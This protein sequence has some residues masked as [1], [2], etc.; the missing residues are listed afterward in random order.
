[1]AFTVRAVIDKRNWRTLPCIIAAMHEQH[2]DIDF[3]HEVMK[4]SAWIAIYGRYIFPEAHPAGF[5]LKV[6][7]TYD[8][9]EDNGQGLIE[10][11]VYYHGKIFTAP[12]LAV[13]E[14]K[15]EMPIVRTKRRDAGALPSV[16]T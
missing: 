9:Y 5:G 6:V 14:T 2:L 11:A 13:L 4:P 12:G 1:M 16:R 8:G 7:Q 15:N 10:V 3:V